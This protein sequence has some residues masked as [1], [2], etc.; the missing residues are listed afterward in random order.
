[1]TMNP[2]DPNFRDGTP[3]DPEAM[4]D[5]SDKTLWGVIAVIAILVAGGLLFY[6]SGGHGPDRTA[7]NSPPA[8]QTGATTGSGPGPTINPPASP[9]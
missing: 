9:K 7:S 3:R 8:T 2:N 5:G 6:S 1:M 4:R